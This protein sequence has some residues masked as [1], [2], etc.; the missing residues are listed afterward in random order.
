MPALVGLGRA[1]DIARAEMVTASAKMAALRDRLITGLQKKIPYVYLNGHPQKRLPGNV[2]L[3]VEFIEGEG[4][5]LFLDQK[6]IYVSSGSACASKALKMSHVLTALKVDAAVG[7]GSVMFSLSKYTAEED[8]DYVLDE[9]PPIVEKLRNMS[10][11]YNHFMK[12]GQRQ[13]AGPGTDYEH[14]HEHAHDEEHDR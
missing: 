2:N 9:F 14:A 7:Q 3:S 12:T 11:L 5:M 8:I 10:P 4:M 6:G 13:A 1:C